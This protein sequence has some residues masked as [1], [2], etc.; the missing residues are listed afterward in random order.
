VDLVQVIQED[1]L[2]EEV[3]ERVDLQVLLQLRLQDHHQLDQMLVQEQVRLLQGR[4]SLERTPYIIAT[5]QAP[6]LIIIEV[7]DH[8]LRVQEVIRETLTHQVEVAVEPLLVRE[9]PG[10]V[11]QD[12]VVLQGLVADHQVADRQV[13]LLEEADKFII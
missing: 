6:S 2:Q 7:Q 9:A 10:Q 5:G 8:H 13:D 4:Q 12:L 11:H 1:H 3:Q